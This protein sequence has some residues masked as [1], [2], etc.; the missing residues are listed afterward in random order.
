VFSYKQLISSLSHLFIPLPEIL[1]FMAQKLSLQYT[2]PCLKFP[3]SLMPTCDTVFLLT[4]VLKL[5]N[6]GFQKV[7]QVTY[8]SGKGVHREV[9]CFNCDKDHVKC[10][11]GWRYK[12]LNCPNLNCCEKKACY[13]AHLKQFP[14]HCFVVIK[15]PLPLV[16]DNHVPAKTLQSLAPVFE[17]TMPLQLNHKTQCELCLEPVG[18]QP[19]MM[20][21]NC[22]EYNICYKCFCENKYEKHSKY[23]VFI[24]LDHEIVQN[25]SGTLKQTF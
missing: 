12:C 15:E 16:P 3:K 5:L 17:F 24:R 21:A 23:H 4:A 11:Q 14:Q 19:R 7:Q 25:Q 2:P 1:S 22:E 9:Y 6:N 8:E 20:C 13:D 18:E 10:V